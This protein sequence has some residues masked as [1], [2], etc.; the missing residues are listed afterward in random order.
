MGAPP[1]HFS[2]VCPHGSGSP[3]V[4]SRGFSD[5]VSDKEKENIGGA[6][7]EYR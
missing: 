3:R 2:R 7:V 4:C 6:T 5:N 1:Y